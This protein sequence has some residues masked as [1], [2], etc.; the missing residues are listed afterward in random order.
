MTIVIK[1]ST[2]LWVHTLYARIKNSVIFFHETVFLKYNLII[3]FIKSTE[4]HYSH[5]NKGYIII[6]IEIPDSHA[7]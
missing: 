7:Y 5:I 6:Y 3:F 4:G 2:L 1:H